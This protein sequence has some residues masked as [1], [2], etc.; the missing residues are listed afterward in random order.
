MDTLDLSHPLQLDDVVAVARH[1]VA[2]R[3]GSE[4][5]AKVQ[6]A[7]AVV[8][9]FVRDHTIARYGINT[10]FGALAEVV[11]ADDQIAA[12]Q[13]NLIRSH[14]C[15]VGPLLPTDVV[16]AMML[17]RAKVLAIG[18][19]G[20]RPQVI[21]TLCEMLNAGLHPL[22]PCQG[23][24]GASGD[25]APLAHLAL[26]LTG[27]GQ[28]ELG[29]VAMTGAQALQQARIAPIVLQAKEGLSL[30][31]GTQAM[32]AIAV[33]ALHRS[34]NICDCADLTGAM[35]VEALLAT[36]KAFDARIVAV[37]PH[38]GALQ[39]AANLRALTAGSPLIASH[40]G[41]ADRKVQDPYSIR[42]M[43]QVHGAVRDALQ[44]VR[45]TLQVEINA[46]TDN[47]LIFQNESGDATHTT[48]LS[49]GNFHGQPVAIACDVARLALVSLASMSERRIEQL[50]NPT[51]N[52]GLPAFLARNSGLNSGFMIAQ[53]TAAALVSESKGLCMP[54]SVDSI[55]S[56]AN[57]EDH[58]SMGPI[59]ARRWAE[60]VA[61]CE[62]VLAIEL[63]CAAQGLDQRAPLQPAPATS[64]AWQVLR[65]RV[66]VMEQDRVLYPDIATATAL[67]RSGELLF[68]A[69]SAVTQ[70]R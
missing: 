4:G 64:A 49:G 8:D 56:S 19:S 36:D 6:A 41:P 66:S 16:R 2:V 14:A 43:P 35:A 42:C 13:T 61:N 22:I 10:G 57:K 7:R 54:A 34:Q 1:Q 25:L 63:L 23:S 52:S 15:G 53:V 29:G 47:P 59:A 21:D 18:H 20:V 32:T 48:I 51:L 67:V 9:A 50:V 39:S 65:Q 60:V 46:V 70:G 38:P 24:V 45:G 5:R 11:I 69:R 33:L 55:P 44:F 68:A 40:A 30:I 3:L 58:V 26:V 17:L 37:R 27:E 28:A 62:I 31:N 12:L